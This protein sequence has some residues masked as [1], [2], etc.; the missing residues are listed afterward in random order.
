MLCAGSVAGKGASPLKAVATISAG[1]KAGV[2]RAAAILASRLSA[3]NPETPRKTAVSISGGDASEELAAA[4][5]DACGLREQSGASA[6]TAIDAAEA[7]AG[8]AK[9]HYLADDFPMVEAESDAV[10]RARSNRSLLP[11][12][13]AATGAALLL[14]ASAA[15]DIAARRAL[16]A[17]PLPESSSPFRPFST[18]GRTASCWR[19]RRRWSRAVASRLGF[20]PS[21]TRRKTFWTAYTAT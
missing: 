19:S 8:Y 10:R 14:A 3:E 17:T 16:R 1:D 13:V 11:A 21:A 5:A 4:L 6:V 2:R 12:A 9:R 20:P 15:H 18:R 7:V